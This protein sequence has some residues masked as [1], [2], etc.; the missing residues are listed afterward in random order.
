MTI[1]DILSLNPVIPVVVIDDAERAVPLASA[2]LDGGLRTIEITLRT[3][4]AL[5]AIARI[6]AALPEIAVGA[7]TILDPQQIEQAQ[8]AGARFLVTPGATPRLLD[9][10]DAS[11]LPYLPGIATASELMTVLERG[12]TAAKLFPAQAVGIALAKALAGPFPDVR[13][14]PTGGIDPTTAP[15]WLALPNV[16]CVGGT[17][18]TRHPLHTEDDFA[19]VTRL[20]RQA[21]ALRRA[22]A[23]APVGERPASAGAAAR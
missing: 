3:P 6:A 13:L 12:V 16:P 8:R 2:L 18:L 17:W 23:A 11:D 1:D 19:E 4:A 10:L 9:A 21:A 22:R 5:D 15:D 14:C 20:A 7:G